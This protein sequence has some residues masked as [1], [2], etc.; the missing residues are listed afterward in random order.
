M[1]EPIRR[2]DDI[3]G[4][5]LAVFIDRAKRQTLHNVAAI[6]RRKAD[7]VRKDGSGFYP[8]D[9]ENLADEIGKMADETTCGLVAAHART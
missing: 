7:Q 4:T 2:L 9:L 6:L 1:S 5:R 3:R 8:E